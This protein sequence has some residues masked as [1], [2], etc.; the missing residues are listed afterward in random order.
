LLCAL[1][2]QSKEN[3]IMFFNDDLGTD[4]AG[5]NHDENTQAPMDAPVADDAAAPS[6]EE[7]AGEDHAA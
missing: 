5:E 1:D 6:T 3:N 2:V 7:V 4:V